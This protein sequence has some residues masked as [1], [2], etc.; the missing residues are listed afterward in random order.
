MAPRRPVNVDELRLQAEE[1]LAVGWF[2]FDALPEPLGFPDH[3]RA[4]LSAAAARNGRPPEPL[5]DRIW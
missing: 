5:P 2:G 1:V 4:M 3:M